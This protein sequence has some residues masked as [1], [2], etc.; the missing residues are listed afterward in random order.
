MATLIIPRI[1]AGV[2]IFATYLEQMRMIRDQLRHD[3][4]ASERRGDR[5]LPN[6]DRAPRPPQKIDRAAQDVVA[7]G[8]AGKR[9]AV[10]LLESYRATREGIEVGSGEFAAAVCAQHV[11]IEAVEKND[12]R[13]FRMPRLLGSHSENLADNFKFGARRETI[14][15]RQRICSR[16]EAAYSSYDEPEAPRPPTPNRHSSSNGFDFCM[17]DRQAA[18]RANL[19]SRRDSGSRRTFSWS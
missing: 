14:G 16:A 11:A 1:E 10:M 12:D 8:N 17:R 5:L 6:L 19:A 3:T 18:H 2:I 9:A 7:S 13:V 4:G 15:H